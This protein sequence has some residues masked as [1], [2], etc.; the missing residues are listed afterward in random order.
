VSVRYQP[1]GRTAAALAESVE[2]GLR[3]GLLVPGEHLPPVREL[4]AAARVSPGTVAAA[5]RLLRSRGIT[6]ADG[7]RGTRIR[8]RPAVSGRAADAA[9]LPPG[10]TDCSTGNPDPELLPDLQTILRR[11]RSEKVLYG[12]ATCLP[13]LAEA[14]RTRLARD[15]VRATAVTATFGALDAIERA[16]ASCLR[17]G[18]RVAV[19]DPGW[20]AFLDLVTATGWTPAPVSVDDEGPVPASLQRALARGAR[21]VV[22]TSRAQNPS[23]A[24]ISED[25]A[26]ELRSLLSAYPDVT[27]LEDDHGVGI[28]DEPLWPVVGTTSNWAFVR[29]AAKAYGPDLRV[30]VVTG[31]DATLGRIDASLALGAGW[32]SHILQRVLLELWRDPGVDALLASATASYDARRLGLMTALSDRGVV[33]RGRSGLNCWIPVDDEAASVG[34]LLRAGWL[35]APGSRFRLGSPPAIRVT[36]AALPIDRAAALAEA[37]DAA[38]G[39]GRGSRARRLA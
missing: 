23:G 32:V 34:S 4:A 3:E 28:V 22:V 27:V 14:T 10:V 24:A 9:D 2:A 29:S 12:A 18:D 33:A 25:R 16:L 21:A 15:G 31:D 7:R 38:F 37:I 36:T 6:S 26:G 30:A 39:G 19:E 13:D 5:Y 17:P 8:E 35:V 1:V 20:A 11:A